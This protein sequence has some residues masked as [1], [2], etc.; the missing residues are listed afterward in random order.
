MCA[1]AEERLTMS[2]AIERRA[3]G[4]SAVGA[5]N[6]FRQKFLGSRSQNHSTDPQQIESRFLRAVEMINHP[7]GFLD[8]KDAPVAVELRKIRRNAFQRLR[9]LEKNYPNIAIQMAA[10]R[11]RG[12]L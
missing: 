10:K 1:I 5:A 6:I 12:L 7:D 11:D 2:T 8:R 9:R 4:F 3:E